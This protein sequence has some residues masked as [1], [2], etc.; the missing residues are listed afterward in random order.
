[1]N[2][3]V[4]PSSVSARAP[5]ACCGARPSSR[6]TSSTCGRIPRSVGERHRVPEGLHERDHEGTNDEEGDQQD[7]LLVVGDG[8]T[9]LARNRGDGVWIAPGG[10]RGALFSPDTR[11]IVGCPPVV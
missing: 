1:M 9:G 4:Q 6:A 8:P 7:V 11:P 5:S 3:T 10:F 2:G